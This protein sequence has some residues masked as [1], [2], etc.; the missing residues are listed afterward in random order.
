MSNKRSHKILTIKI[1]CTCP[2]A[3][4]DTLYGL[5]W[6]KI[7]EGIHQGKRKTDLKNELE[8]LSSLMPDDSIFNEVK[9]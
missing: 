8:I 1:R 7:N 4:K 5:L 2:Q 9:N 6:H 3:T